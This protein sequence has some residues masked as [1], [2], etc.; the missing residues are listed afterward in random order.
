[1]CER[2]QSRFQID[3]RNGIDQDLGAVKIAESSLLG[4]DLVGDRASI[5]QD[6]ARLRLPGG[7]LWRI[8]ILSCGRDS[9]VGSA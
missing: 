4:P 5:N 8:Y 1:M 2:E 3:E 7:A 9:I 6:L